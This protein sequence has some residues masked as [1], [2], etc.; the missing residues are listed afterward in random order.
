MDGK[1]K[2]AVL[3]NKAKEELG[4]GFFFKA[5]ELFEQAGENTTSEEEKIKAYTEALLIHIR[6]KGVPSFSSAAAASSMISQLL[7]STS[8]LNASLYKQIEEHYL[9]IQEHV[10]KAKDEKTLELLLLKIK[11]CF[12][13]MDHYPGTALIFRHLGDIAHDNSCKSGTWQKKTIKYYRES[14]YY[15]EKAGIWK[16]AGETYESAGYANRKQKHLLCRRNTLLLLIHIQNLLNLLKNPWKSGHTSLKLPSTT[17]PT[18]APFM[19]G[20][21]M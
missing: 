16:D 17:A 13:H 2:W 11:D 8:P 7:A 12:L 21:R 9:K 3:F 20:G 10:D 19:P 15:F 14:A 5:A 18:V 1:E 6:P 4:N